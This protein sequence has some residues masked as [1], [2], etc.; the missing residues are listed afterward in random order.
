MQGFK[1]ISQIRPSYHKNIYTKQ[2]RN[3]IYKKE[4]YV[5]DTVLQQSKMLHF[6][7]EID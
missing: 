7:K 3:L 1:I 6:V 4:T 5:S 2:Q